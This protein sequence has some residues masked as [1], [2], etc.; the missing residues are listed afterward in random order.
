VSA[1]IDPFSRPHPLPRY[2]RASEVIADTLRLRILN[3]D[4][5]EGEHLPTQETLLEEFR[6]SKPTLRE[7]LR[8][9][10]NEGLITVKRGNVGGSAVHRPTA[11]EVAYT[12]A[13]ILRLRGADLMD[14]RTSL[15]ILEPICAA[16]CASRDDR[17]TEVVPVLRALH[18]RSLAELD[19]PVMLAQMTTEFH[20]Q[21][22]QL[23]G[24]TTIGLVVGALQFLWQAH[25]NAW[26]SEESRG[27][28]GELPDR[29]E[30]SHG[31]AEH[32]TM[33]ALIE[34]GDVEGTYHEARRHVA[35]SI[36]LFERRMDR[37]IDFGVVNWFR[38]H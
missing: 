23:S 36:L 18:E 19:D 17:A 30:R 22:V 35:Q 26:L 1:V 8:T 11:D 9:L 4:I 14:L 38:Q 27:D 29:H 28:R 7:A 15:Q 3:G 5:K 6:V 13:L 2:P 32:E 20:A 21:L 12:L 34:A 10:E 24:N 31:L 37:Q 33:L 16:L 25:T